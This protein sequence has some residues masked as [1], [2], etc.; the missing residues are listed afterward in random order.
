VPLTLVA[1][2]SGKHVLCEKPFAIHAAELDALRPY[3]SQV[4]IREAFMVRHHPQ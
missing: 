4:H 1:V 2:R 3:A